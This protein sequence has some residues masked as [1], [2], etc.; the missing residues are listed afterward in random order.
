MQTFDFNTLLNSIYR[1]D[2]SGNPADPYYSMT[3]LATGFTSAIY[4]FSFNW[5]IDQD[6]YADYSYTYFMDEADF[7]ENYK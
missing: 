1:M 4:D 7:M 2:D 3:N 6:M 5:T